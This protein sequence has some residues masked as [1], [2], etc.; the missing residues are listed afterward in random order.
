MEKTKV[1]GY[2]EVGHENEKGHINLKERLKDVKKEKDSKLSTK[3]TS[4]ATTKSSNELCSD[5]SPKYSVSKSAKMIQIFG[6]SHNTNERAKTF[7]GIST[8][9]DRN[10]GMLSPASLPDILA[11]TE[12][13][14][15]AH[16]SQKAPAF[17]RS[18]EGVLSQDDD[19]DE[20]GNQ[21]RPRHFSFGALSKTF[22]NRD[23]KCQVSRKSSPLR[24]SPITRI[25]KICGNS[26]FLKRHQVSTDNMASV[27]TY[28][29]QEINSIHNFFTGDDEIPF[30]IPPRY[31]A[32]KKERKASND[33]LETERLR[34]LSFSSF[35]RNR[36]AYYQ[37]K[38][39]NIEQVC[40]SSYP[41][42]T[43]ELE[44]Y[45]TNLKLSRAQQTLSRAG[46]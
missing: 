28:S 45:L 39:E 41:R 20:H 22:W 2:T 32:I 5:H 14:T 11:S 24:C 12:R 42:A 1:C 4:P 19:E 33:P 26:P 3:K 7:S 15:L 6:K 17:T 10:R 31:S 18:F 30:A 38:K 46:L 23:G 8:K 34:L 9:I 40:N 43:A 35:F 36:F 21:P 37:K 25:R 27:H 29:M 13:K 16:C 44:S